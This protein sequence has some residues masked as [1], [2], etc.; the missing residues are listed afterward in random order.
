MMTNALQS[1]F[2]DASA[3]HQGRLVTHGAQQAAQQGPAGPTGPSKSA[4][5]QSM[6]QMALLRVAAAEY[7]S[8]PQDLACTLYARSCDASHCS[9]KMQALLII[10]RHE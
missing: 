6:S 2:A 10:E 9:L 4:A 5:M 3:G 8:A 7:P 1:L